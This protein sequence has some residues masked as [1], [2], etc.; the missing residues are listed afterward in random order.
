MSETILDSIKK[1][2][3]KEIELLKKSTSINS[4]EKKAMEASKPLNFLKA[5]KSKEKKAF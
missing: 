2:K 1:Y 4:L 5:L 3:I